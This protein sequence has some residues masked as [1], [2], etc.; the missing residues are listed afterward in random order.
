VG[1]M[2]YDMASMQLKESAMLKEVQN[3]S[4]FEAFSGGHIPFVFYKTVRQGNFVIEGI[5]KNEN[6]WDS[7]SLKDTD[8]LD[9][10]R[11]DCHIWDDDRILIV[12]SG[13]EKEKFKQRIY[14]AVSHDRGK[15]WITQR[16]DNK[17]FD[18]T[19]SW[20]PRMAV[21]G[22]NVAVVWEDSRDIRSA[23]RLRLSADRGSTWTK[24]D[25]AISGKTHYAFRPR[26][27]FADHM[28]NAVW[29]QFGD[30]EK[31][32]AD[33]AF[34]KFNW[35]EAVQIAS[36]Q[37]NAINREKK[38]TLLRECVETY[39]KAMI[40]KD[41]KTSYMLHD[42]FYRARIP[43]DYY[44]AHRGP[45]VYQSFRIE[46]IRIEGNIADVRVTVRYEIPRFAILGRNTSVPP[47]DVMTEDT[48]L[49]IDGAWHR[50]FVDALS[51]GSAIDY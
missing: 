15:S 29:Y 51:G 16:I 50:K 45:M 36:R 49:F 34:M 9:V 42:P 13:E 26:I 6:G 23:I 27:S 11:M 22:S 14:A 33:L 48:Y 32:T 10:A 47:R 3:I 43:F 39:W 17:D 44:S 41:L 19:R 37:D 35:A 28:F 30:D 12:F 21:D 5:A 8:G 24:N 1:T 46:N 18:N 25:S 2:T 38:G 40:E 31:R 4:F 7:F 20:L